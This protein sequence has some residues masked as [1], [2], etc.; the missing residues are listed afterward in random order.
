M[1]AYALTEN[2]LIV[3]GSLYFIA[4]KH[5]HDL[6]TPTYSPTYESACNTEPEGCMQTVTDSKEQNLG[7]RLGLI[8]VSV[9]LWS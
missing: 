8:N 1:P 3:K 9:V 5:T 4:G 7:K 6:Q 2:Y